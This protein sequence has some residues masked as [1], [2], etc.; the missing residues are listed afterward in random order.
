MKKNLIIT[1]LC[2]LVIAIIVVIGI[3]FADIFNKPSN[4]IENQQ[5]TENSG[6]T[7]AN[8]ENVQ[9][10]NNITDKKEN[11]TIMS[12][13]DNNINT[14]ETYPPE[15]IVQKPPVENNDNIQIKPE[16][17][18]EPKPEPE[19]EPKP[20][21]DPKPEPEPE[22]SPVTNE[23]ISES[24][25]EFSLTKG[26]DAKTAYDTL[27]SFLNSKYSI[28]TNKQN[29]LPANFVPT[30]LVVP[31]GCQYQMER[32]AANALVSLLSAAKQNGIY[33]LVLYS[34]YRT[35]ASQKN[36]FE[37]RT[38]RYLNQGYS[39]AEAEAKAGEYIAPPGASEHNTGLAADVSSS[40]I[41]NKYG[42]LT[43][44]FDQT[45]S[46]QWMKNNCA[47]YGFI[48]RYLKGKEGIT[49]YSYEPW[50]IRYIGKEH[51]TACTAL[52]ITYEEY[53]SLLL[54]Y[55]EQ[56]KADAGV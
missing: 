31:S 38:N 39:R 6:D 15:T 11:D 54:K 14:D 21:P 16:P 23:K 13:K 48:I 45:K 4:E 33:D 50:H 7:T 34:G 5:I 51:A 37:T 44:H 20:E 25:K 2:I 19:P 41:V 53:Y 26:M 52:G 40:T 9:D 17:E 1:G 36:K 29:R 22:T 18:P 10:N 24:Y 35:Y 55:R 27:N 3:L 49:G 12:E 56:A 8:D 32:T 28:L 30:D 42:S 47:N 43:D 46:Y